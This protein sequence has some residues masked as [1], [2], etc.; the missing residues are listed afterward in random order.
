MAGEVEDTFNKVKAGAK[1]GAKEVTDPGSETS[2][3]T[4]YP[5]SP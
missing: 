5:D 3:V 2:I 1:A 4:K